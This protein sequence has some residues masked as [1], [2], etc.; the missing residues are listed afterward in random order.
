MSSDQTSSV[1]LSPSPP[2]PPQTVTFA[3]VFAE[4]AR[5]I[6]VELDLGDAAGQTLD[7]VLQADLEFTDVASGQ[8][9]TATQT[10]RLPRAADSECRVAFY[11]SLFTETLSIIACCCTSQAN[12]KHSLLCNALHELTANLHSNQPPPLCQSCPAAADSAPL[13]R[14]ELVVTTAARFATS[15]AI[16]AALA[17]GQRRA[18]GDAKALLQDVIGSLS[19]DAGKVTD[20]KLAKIMEVLQREA[21]DMLDKVSM[22]QPVFVH[23]MVS[24]FVYCSAAVQ[25]ACKGSG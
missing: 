2:P 25:I 19:A 13:A 18:F 10:L 15:D 23:R 16:A 4:E 12:Q 24:A 5:E 11:K 20:P 14:S 21:Q 1:L 8:R 17:A 9:C 7:C 6:L 3:D 22:A